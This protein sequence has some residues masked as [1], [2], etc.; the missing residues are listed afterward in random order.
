MAMGVVVLVDLGLGLGLGRESRVRHRRWSKG[1]FSVLRLRARIDE[2]E[3]EECLD[4]QAG[5]SK[6]VIPRAKVTT[7]TSR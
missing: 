3:K 5:L 4:L 6:L 7:G 2:A 1:S